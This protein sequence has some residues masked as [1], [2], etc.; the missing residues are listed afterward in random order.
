MDSPQRCRG[1]IKTEFREFELAALGEIG[2]NLFLADVF[3]RRSLLLPQ[4]RA[5]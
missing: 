4:I 3:P 1:G 2:V 5:K